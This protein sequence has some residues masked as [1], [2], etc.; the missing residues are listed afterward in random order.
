MKVEAYN[1]DPIL[2]EQFVNYVCAQ[3]DIFPNKITVE[4]WPETFDDGKNGLI[5][6]N[7]EEEYTLMVCTKD[8]EFDQVLYI[9]G[10]MLE[11]VKQIMIENNSIYQ[12]NNSFYM[13]SSNNANNFVQNYVDILTNMV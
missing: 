2:T 10:K 5:Y 1:I 12:V 3:I 11:E 9:I 4:A 8:L 6:E 7:G 13:P